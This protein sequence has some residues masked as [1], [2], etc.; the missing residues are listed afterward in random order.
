MLFVSIMATYFNIA[1]N[2]L[3]CQS[4]NFENESYSD[5]FFS[6]MS[7]HSWQLS[8]FVSTSFKLLIEIQLALNF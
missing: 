8:Q 3:Q 7:E 4:M 6:G 5:Y 2:D 1:Y